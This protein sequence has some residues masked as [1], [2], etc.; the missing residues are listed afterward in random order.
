[1]GNGIKFSSK[2]I[3]FK[4]IKRFT[5]LFSFFSLNEIDLYESKTGQNGAW[6]QKSTW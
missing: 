2:T 5:L 6:Q 1:M 4:Y 3:N